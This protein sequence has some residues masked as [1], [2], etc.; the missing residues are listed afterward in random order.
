MRLALAVLLQ[1]T[2]LQL[3]AQLHVSSVLDNKRLVKRFLTGD[4]VRISNV[5]YRGAMDARGSFRCPNCTLPIDSGIVLSTGD[6]RY[7]QGPNNSP[8]SSGNNGTWGDK[9]LEELAY[10][11]TY[12]A[13]ILEFDFVTEEEVISFNYVFGSE[14]Y[15]EYVGS[16]FNDVFA[17]LLTDVDRGTSTN[18]AHIPGSTIPI[19]INTLNSNKFSAFYIPN[20]RFKPD[21]DSLFNLE[22]DGM[23]ELLTAYALVEPGR[24][25]HIKIAIADVNDQQLD[26]GVFIE[27]GSFSSQP[28]DEFIAANKAYF[29]Y[30]STELKSMNI[31]PARGD[32]VF[33]AATGEQSIPDEPTVHLSDTSSKTEVNKTLVLYFPFDEDQITP[34]GIEELSAFLEAIP[35]DAVK[36]RFVVKGHTDNKGTKAYNV[37]LSKRRAEAVAALLLKAGFKRHQIDASNYDY[38]QPVRDHLTDKNRAE[39]R[40]VE[41]QVIY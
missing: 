26:S 20:N 34:G 14:E 27:G 5:Q 12:D 33:S 4:A 24:I 41:V 30:F 15:E 37:D 7:L 11:T 25:Y 3:T 13:A 18:L 35:N 8:S 9:Q 32:V 21:S 28:K 23:S 38:T 29:N 17:F 40:R 1:F 31:S 39:N 16:P 10:G 6:V 2:V 22:L 19:T 36:V